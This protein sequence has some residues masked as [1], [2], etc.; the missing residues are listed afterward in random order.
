VLVWAG[1]AIFGPQTYAT[2]Q[3]AGF[4]VAFII[5]A[6]FAL[7]ALEARPD[8][9]AL[10]LVVAANAVMT[11]ALLPLRGYFSAPVELLLLTVAGAAIYGF[12]VLG[13]N[14]AG[15]RKIIQQARARK[16]GA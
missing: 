7:S 2:A 11:A 10:A 4:L 8:F 6:F 13:G 3:T 15:C 5:T 14:I 16:T 12:L 9:K 1:P